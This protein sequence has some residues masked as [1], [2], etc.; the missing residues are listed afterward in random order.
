LL[1]DGQI[2]TLTLTVS[3]ENINDALHHLTVCRNGP[4]ARGG[5]HP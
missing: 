3:Y 4:A 5:E 1:A 2:S